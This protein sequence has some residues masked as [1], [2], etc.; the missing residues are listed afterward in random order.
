MVDLEPLLESPFETA[1]NRGFE[2]LVGAGIVLL[3]AVAV[4]GRSSVTTALVALYLL[5]LPGYLA[6]RVRTW[7][8]DDS[9]TDES[10]ES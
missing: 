7:E 9:T 1:S 5:A 6:Y 2:T 8:R 10:S 3:A 4:F